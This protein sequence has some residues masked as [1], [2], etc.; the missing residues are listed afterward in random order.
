M[1]TVVIPNAESQ[2]GD[3]FTFESSE[4]YSV[5]T[6]PKRAAFTGS[7]YVT[8]EGNSGLIGSSTIIPGQDNAMVFYDNQSTQDLFAVLGDG[9]VEF[10]NSSS[11]P[12][13]VNVEPGTI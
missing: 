13:V 5:E 11:D 7:T 10:N 6:P 3:V 9:F 2:P 1:A 4:T 8:R 12:I